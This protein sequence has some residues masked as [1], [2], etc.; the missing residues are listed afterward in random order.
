MPE[1]RAQQLSN[2]RGGAKNEPVHVVQ[3]I[4]STLL[5]VASAILLIYGQNIFGLVAMLVGGALAFVRF[6]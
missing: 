5:L 1:P 3:M 2:R 6:H 4:V